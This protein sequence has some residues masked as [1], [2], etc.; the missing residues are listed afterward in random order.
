MS[1]HLDPTSTSHPHPK[2][3]P[4]PQ[5]ERDEPPPKD[6]L[7]ATAQDLELQQAIRDYVPGTDA[8]T[9]LVRQI[10]RH[11]LPI[12]WLMYVLNYVDRTNIGN[13][14]SAGMDVDLQLE[15]GRYAWVISIFFFGYLIMEV[16]SN[17]ILSR[18]RPSLFLPGIMIV[19]G[20]VSAAMASVQNYGAILAFRFV[21]GCIESGFFPGV[22][23]VMSC[24]YKNAEIGKRFAIF[25]SAAVM[26]GAFGG[27]L[28][29]A[30]TG[31]LDGARGMAGWRWLFII[32]GLATVGV[33]ITATFILLDFPH[34]STALTL[35]QRQLAAVRI[36]VDSQ[37]AGGG[38]RLSH[39]EAF[40]AAAVDPATYAFML[41]LVLD[42]GA[43]TISYFI[44]TITKTL[45]Y[46]TTA[47]QYMTVPI[48]VT[49]AVALNVLAWNADRIWP[50][51]SAPRYTLGWGV[52]AG[53]LGGG[54]LVALLVPAFLRGVPPRLTRAERG[55]RARGEVLEEA[56]AEQA[57][58]RGV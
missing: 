3:D 44:P 40:T 18:A 28:A 23:F 6:G 45:G 10:D 53:F 57:D 33:A 55:R 36:L 13:A 27:I 42:S 2:T 1:L 48:Y 35:E 25:Y 5:I 50:G 39:G 30:I 52:T 24:W 29:G 43:G 15:G 19:W 54:A 17:M 11:L 56:G 9:K 58:R 49:A 34:T 21:L 20:A 31:H 51:S 16:P 12:L 46:S 7:R 37:D 47:A 41:L 32:E 26:S 14:K 22:L 8:E 38:E 4:L